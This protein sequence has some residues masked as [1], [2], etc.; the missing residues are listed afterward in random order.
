MRTI[1]IGKDEVIWVKEE[2]VLNTAVWP[3]AA[4]AI[5]LIDEPDF[6]QERA[7]IEDKQK[8]L[9]RSRLARVAGPYKGGVFTGVRTYIKP[10]GSL[11]VAPVPDTLLKGL[12]GIETI[13]GAT[14]VVYTLGTID[15]ALISFTILH[16]K[17]FNTVL[18]TGCVVDKGT[19]PVKAGVGDDALGEG[20]FDGVYLKSIQTGTDALNSTIDGSITPVTEIPLKGTKAAKMYDVGQKIVVGTNDNS[21]AGWI[22]TARDIAASPN[23]LTIT[24]GVDDEQLEDAV[25]KGWVP[26]ITE[27]GNLIHGRFGQVQENIAAAGL[28]DLDIIDSV[29]EITNGIKVLEDEKTNTAWPESIVVGDRQVT[30]MINRYFKKDASTY[31]YDAEEQVSRIVNIPVGATAAYRYLFEIP[32]FQFDTPKTSGEQ[33]KITALTGIAFA[34]ASLDDEISMTLD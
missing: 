24:G 18:Y 30:L 22:I 10:S 33:E 20:T 4:D 21:G 8:R 9:T 27:A 25:V 5:L 28:T 17:G 26:A 6:T 11:G 34:S 14:S 3:E 2:T 16:K 32:D 31:K 15:A 1:A 23:T 29:I 12:F 19:F 7:F 13:N